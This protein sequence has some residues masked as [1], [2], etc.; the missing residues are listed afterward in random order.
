MPASRLQIFACFAESP[1]AISE[2]VTMGGVPSRIEGARPPVAPRKASV[3]AEEPSAYLAEARNLV[4][5]HMK[6]ALPRESRLQPFYN[7]L[8]EYP[9]RAAKSMRPALCIA[10]CRAF[11]G[12]LEDVAPT[13]ASLEMFH[14]A[15]LVHDDIEDDSY[16]RRGRPTLHRKF[17]VPIAVNVGDAL[18]AI[19]LLP[20]AGNFSSLASDVARQVLDVTVRMARETAEGQAMEL[21]WIRWGGCTLTDSEYLRLALKKTCWYSFLAP[22]LTGAAIAGA[23][24]AAV[25]ALQRFAGWLGIA[26][27]IHDDILN[28]EGTV[29]D[30]GKEIGGDLIEGKYTLILMHAL[31]SATPA[32]R[33]AGLRVLR[34]SRSLRS[35][36]DVEFLQELI[37][38]YHSLT[39]ARYMAEKTAGRARE[40]LARVLERVR[41]TRHTRFLSAVNDY[42][43]TRAR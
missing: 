17:G 43:V 27:Q 39:Y 5:A 7:L 4:L 36:Q 1:W 40:A 6:A 3:A 24:A 33:A 26:F 31:R 30:Y 38:R 8:L 28:L 16:L 20:L 2:L 34:R 29:T 35:R 18:L 11:G 15:F 42:C 14:N 32:E 41:P 19:G 9:L 37:N 10:V 23:P 12:E 25:R 22:V 13:A 21:S